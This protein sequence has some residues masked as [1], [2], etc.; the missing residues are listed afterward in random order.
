MLAC[1]QPLPR[2]ARPEAAAPEPAAPEP[3][4]P[5][6]AA[7]EAVTPDLALTEL[8]ARAGQQHPRVVR[9]LRYRDE[10]RVWQA[11]GAVLL[12]GRGLAGRFEVAIEVDEQCRGQGLGARLAVAARRLVPAGEPLWAQI[13]PG[14]A[15]SVRAFLPGRLPPRGRRGAAQRTRR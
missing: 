10:V 12:I 3:G 6:R 7:N 11:N 4:A 2:P 5:E 15:A 13:A 14:N 8:T 9:A 1:A